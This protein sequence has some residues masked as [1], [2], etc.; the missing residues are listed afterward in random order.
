MIVADASAV[1]AAL[2]ND[3]PARR[4]LSSLPI[5]A[6]HLV[7]VEVVSVLRR[8]SLGGQLDPSHAERMIIVLA[9]LGIR[10]HGSA[11][12]LGRVWQ[13]RGNLT[14]YDATYVALAETLTCPLLTAD[15][16][17]ANAF[18]PRCPIQLVPG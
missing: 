16:R 17:L 8:L 2:L 18:G 7:D 4:S 15:R 12:L 14:A 5:H 3:G 11:D 9:T 6:P 10:L 13:L 1:V